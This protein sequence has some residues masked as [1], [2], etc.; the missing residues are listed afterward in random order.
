MPKCC[1]FQCDNRPTLNYLQLTQHVNKHACDVLNYDYIFQETTIPQGIHP[2]TYKIYTILQFI[3]NQLQFNR[4]LRYD[5]LI[6][7]DSDAWIQN[8]DLLTRV[9]TNLIETPHKHGCYSRD[10]YT[11][12]NTFI[13][14]GSFILKIDEYT[15]AMY[16][17]IANA[18]EKNAAHRNKWPFDQWYISN[19]V[20][21]H[22]DDFFVY[23]PDIMNTPNGKVLRHN[24]MKNKR[25]HDDLIE[26]LNNKNKQQQPQPDCDLKISDAPFPNPHYIVYEY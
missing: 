1:V 12:N 9:V 2:A 25:M 8:T 11:K 3:E 19:Y 23:E 21:D 15:L 6:F 14:S 5:V 16:K 18:L 7:L 24:W 10:P 22:R 17:E 13:N 4:D 26:L 20:F